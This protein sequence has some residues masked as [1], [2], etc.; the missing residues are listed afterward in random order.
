M[1][2]S[3]QGKNCL[4]VAL[5]SDNIVCFRLL[6]KKLSQI[7]QLSKNQICTILDKTDDKV[8]HFIY[9]SVLSI[10]IIN[11]YDITRNVI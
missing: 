4:M 5:E 8:K 7:K 10:L 6:M 11:D 1:L 9:V 3:I 2:I